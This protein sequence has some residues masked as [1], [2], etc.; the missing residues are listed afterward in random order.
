[1][2][3]PVVPDQFGNTTI[4]GPWAALVDRAP[5]DDQSHAPLCRS[6]R[7]VD[8]PGRYPESAIQAG[9]WWDDR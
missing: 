8:T 4:F 5:A 7:T 9:H 6:L 3:G 2:L 1:M